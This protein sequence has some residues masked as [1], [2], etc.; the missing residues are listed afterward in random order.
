MHADIAVVGGGRAG[1]KAARP[2]AGVALASPGQGRARRFIRLD[3]P[4]FQPMVGL[5]LE[6]TAFGL[7]SGL[8]GSFESIASMLYTWPARGK[9]EQKILGFLYR[10]TLPICNLNA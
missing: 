8:R 6:R 10:L 5:D 3:A 4:S 9:N 2:G 7:G 1:L